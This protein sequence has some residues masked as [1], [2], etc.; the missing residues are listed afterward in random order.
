MPSVPSPISGL[1]FCSIDEDLR[2]ESAPPR[3]SD[4]GFEVPLDADVEPS[5]FVMPLA[6]SSP[7][8]PPPLEDEDEAIE[9]GPPPVDDQWPD[10]PEQASEMDEDAPGDEL[11]DST[12]A[13]MI[14][15]TRQGK[16]KMKAGWKISRHGHAYP[17]FP[18]ATVKR[19]AEE[20]ARTSGIGNPR[21]GRE[22]LAA[23]QQASDWFFEQVAGDL[24]AYAVHAGRKTINESDME[25]VMKRQVHPSAGV[26]IHCGIY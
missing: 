14:S 1:M 16:S 26:V 8:R 18:P 24:A 23:F 4:F 2:R 15:A 3:P 11:E 17:P 12:T 22:T 13:E 10:M 7:E 9:N 25:L 21:M 20:F 6:Q 5:T 19:I